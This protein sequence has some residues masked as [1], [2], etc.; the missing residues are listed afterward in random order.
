MGL[1]WQEYWSGLPFAPPGDL[2][3][4][5]IKPES[6]SLQEE[7]LPS[8]YQGS[9]YSEGAEAKSFISCMPWAKAE[10][11]AI[12]KDIPKVTKDSHRFAE[13]F[14]IVIQTYQRAFSDLYQ[15]LQCI[16]Q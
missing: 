4:P 8:E 2:P 13:K 16:C 14:N 1:S 11:Q 7:S 3:D 12:V 5:G 15:L 9:L 10:L 6:P